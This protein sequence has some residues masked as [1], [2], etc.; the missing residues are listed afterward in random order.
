MVQKVFFSFLTYELNSLIQCSPN[1]M[2]SF[3]I[4]VKREGRNVT[5]NVPIF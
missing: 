1:V 3:N 5:M 4:Q 2:I